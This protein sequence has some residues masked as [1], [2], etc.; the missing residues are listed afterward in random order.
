MVPVEEREVFTPSLAGINPRSPKT[1][2]AKG[3]SVSQQGSA[4][5]HCAPRAEAEVIP[6]KMSLECD[7]TSMICQC[8]IHPR[9]HLRRMQPSI[10]LLLLLLCFTFLTLIPISDV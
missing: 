5:L 7:D 4:S 3:K 2:P 10:F 9:W 1:P 8:P 6:W